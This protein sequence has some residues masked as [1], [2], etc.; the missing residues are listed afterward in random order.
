[1]TTSSVFVLLILFLIAFIYM[2]LA[3]RFG[4]ID[5][6][7]HR[8]SHTHSTVRGG[9][10]LFP[11]A[12]ILWWSMSDFQHSWMILGLILIA[13]VSLLDDIYSL[14]GKVRMGVQFIA[15]S[16]AF[17]DLGLYDQE[18][19]WTLPILYFIGI[20]VF[21]CVNFMDG[22]NGISG[23]YGLVFFGTILA[24]NTYLPIFEESLIRYEILAIFV[25]L[26]FNLR[27]KAIM[28]AGDIG[29]VS[30]AFLMV[31]F[32]AQWYM[33]QHNWTIVLLLLVYGIDAFL[34][35]AKRFKNGEDLGEPHRQHL[36]QLLANQAKKPHIQIAL[37][38]AL[39]QLGINLIFFI[40]PNQGL[41]SWIAAATLFVSGGVY[42]LI[43]KSVRKKYHIQ[44]E[45]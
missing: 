24:I 36:Y 22:I 19:M 12:A 2:K 10:I 45:V 29:S 8:S 25:F 28:F 26:I 18:P 15:L 1:M 13:T 3:K 43:K 20:G 11:I 21:N 33:S 31:Y 34:T 35:L 41:P 23:L 5:V 38:F 39:V 44:S 7:N 6:P 32:M 9:G 4:I 37:L 30:L 14:S 27:K 42:L 16:M 40:L 17:Y